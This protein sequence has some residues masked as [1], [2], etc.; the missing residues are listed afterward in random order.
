MLADTENSIERVVGMPISGT[1][2]AS[3][4][5]RSYH[6]LKVEK[7]EK[8]YLFFKINLLSEEEGSM[9]MT[10]YEKGE[11]P[12]LKACQKHS[13]DSCYISSDKLR[14]NMTLF[15]IINC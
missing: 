4:E 14:E 2:S 15:L 13:F 6:Y 8:K 9:G 10:I 1:A 5:G 7:I 12:V 3:S 11:S